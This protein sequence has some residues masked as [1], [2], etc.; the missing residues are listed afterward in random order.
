MNHSNALD[1]NERH[2]WYS[3]MVDQTMMSKYNP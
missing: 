3:I 2:D 1:R